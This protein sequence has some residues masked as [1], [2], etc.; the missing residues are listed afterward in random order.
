MNSDVWKVIEAVEENFE[1][2]V[3]L[4]EVFYGKSSRQDRSATESNLKAQNQNIR[5]DDMAERVESW[6]TE[7]SRK[8]AIAARM[9]LAPGDVVPVLGPLAARL[10]GQ[11]VSTSDLSV[12]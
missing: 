5:P 12:F 6:M 7:A 4:N 2:R 8:E 11:F 9:L 3:G 1:K 10:W